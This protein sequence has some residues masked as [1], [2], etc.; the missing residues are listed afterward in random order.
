MTCREACMK[1]ANDAIRK[2]DMKT[3]LRMIR[4]ATVVCKK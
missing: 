2:G 4:L 3:H 1:A